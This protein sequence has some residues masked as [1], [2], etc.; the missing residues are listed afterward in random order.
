ML[1]MMLATEDETRRGFRPDLT[2]AT[3]VAR[4]GRLLVVEEHV[5]GAL[6]LNQPAGHLEPEESLV[7]AA[8][9]E[10]REETGWDVTITA[11]VGIYR[12]TAPDGVAF[13]R[14]AF[15]A[16]PRH[17]HADQPL[18]SGIERALWM[19]PTELRAASHRMRSPLVMLA[20]ED[21]LA[22]TRLPLSA[23]RDLG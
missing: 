10:T 23:L 18:D 17:H 14:F 21:F 22:G 5:R 9:R 15:A 1:P 19:T 11:L 7:A 8:V 16:E 13:L 20:A 6:V 3:L 2:V 12:W 4:E